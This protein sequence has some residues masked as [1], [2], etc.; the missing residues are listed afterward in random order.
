MEVAATAASTD[1][2]NVLDTFMFEVLIMIGAVFTVVYVIF[3]YAIDIVGK[4]NL[5]SEYF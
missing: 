3:A 5:L 1:C 4:V 2:S